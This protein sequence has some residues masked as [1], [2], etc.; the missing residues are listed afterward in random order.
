MIQNVVG[1]SGLKP[2]SLQMSEELILIGVEPVKLVPD[3]QT[4]HLLS[5]I[6]VEFMS[7]ELHAMNSIMLFML[8]ARA[9]VNLQE[10]V[11]SVETVVK[12]MTLSVC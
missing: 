1:N 9:G 8:E 7:G 10:M 3:A 4:Y 6:A 2:W 5:L 12:W 11:R